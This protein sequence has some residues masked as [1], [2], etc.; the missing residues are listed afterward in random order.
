MEIE[1]GSH[2][3]FLDVDVYRRHDGSLGHRVYR[4]LTQTS[5]YLSAAFHHHLVNKWAIL[6][7]LF[8][9]TKMICSPS[10]LRQEFKFLHQNFQDK[11]CSE[12]HILRALDPPT[13]ATPQRNE[14]PASVAFLQFVGA[15]FCCISGV[16]TKH[17]GGGSPAK[18]ALQLPLTH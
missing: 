4:K 10:S 16:L 17:E 15:T 3:A 1:R 18:E 2:I 6:S 8:H 14:D 5:Q 9:R 11:G 12:R 13:R 7:I